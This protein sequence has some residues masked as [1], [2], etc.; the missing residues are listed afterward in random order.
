M[1]TKNSGL[2]CERLLR[3]AVIAQPIAERDRRQARRR[4]LDVGL[5]EEEGEAEPNSIMA[6]PMATSLTR[7]SLQM[8]PCMAPSSMPTTPAASTPTQGEPV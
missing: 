8:K 6:M 5:A 1:P 3:I 7:G 2:T 4:R